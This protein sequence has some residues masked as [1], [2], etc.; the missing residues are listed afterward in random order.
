MTEM[1]KF[2]K[3]FAMF[4]LIA[5][6][7]FP[8]FTTN[9]NNF[10]IFLLILIIILLLGKRDSFSAKRNI[11]VILLTLFLVM[12]QAILFQYFKLETIL[13][14]IIRT[15]CAL[16]VVYIVKGDFIN[17]YI[18]QIKLLTLISFFIF[19]PIFIAPGILDLISSVVP[20]FMRFNTTILGVETTKPSLILV[21]LNMD[22]PSRTY[23]RNCGPFWEPGAFGGFLLI[24]ILFNFLKGKTI[25]DK[26]NYVFYIGLFTTFSTTAYLAFFLLIL[27]YFISEK[28]IA[29]YKVLILGLL[30][31]S[32]YLLFF[33]INFM[34][35][36]ISK[37]ISKIDFAIEEAGGDTRFASA[38]L[39]LME[40]VEYPISGRGLWPETRIGGKLKI[41][42][43][44]NGLTN[45][46]T[47]WGI[48]FFIVYFYLLYKNFE[49]L[50]LQQNNLKTYFA[51]LSIIVICVLS[52]GE[53]YFSAIFFW[54][55]VLIP[56]K[57]L[58]YTI[59]RDSIQN[60]KYTDYKKKY[61]LR[62]LKLK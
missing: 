23:N 26:S 44:N 51:F 33:Q 48:V 16:L 10:I 32:F 29:W 49:R 61:N 5:M 17:L 9:K 56:F 40:F 36:K 30:S 4:G 35:K 60:A 59:K 6:S 18:K 28:K 15:L 46:L 50:L 25:T 19:I 54:S 45:F 27:S 1:E 39:D 34:N 43:R 21:N 7:G 58:I 22:A 37:E 41:I 11:L 20:S 24:A 38:V 14:F 2:K 3:L 57:Y 31:I 42:V 12:L 53:N 55:L 8:F 13:G 47:T 52:V 62:M